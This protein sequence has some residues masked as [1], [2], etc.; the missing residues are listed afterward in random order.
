MFLCI[1]I[2]SAPWTFFPSSIRPWFME[3]KIV[4]YSIEKWVCKTA[5]SNMFCICIC[6]YLVEFAPLCSICRDIFNCNLSSSNIFCNRCFVDTL[7]I[8]FLIRGGTMVPPLAPTF[9]G[10]PFY[11]IFPLRLLYAITFLTLP[12]TSLLPTL[13]FAFSLDIF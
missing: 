1:I 4:W 10:V 2:A 3:R 5:I 6:Y 12:S 13:I 8:P 9:N 7:K 11:V